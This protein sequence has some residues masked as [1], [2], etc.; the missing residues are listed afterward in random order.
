M[1]KHKS[2][3]FNVIIQKLPYYYGILFSLS[4]FLY[5]YLCVSLT[6]WFWWVEKKPLDFEEVNLNEQQHQQQQKKMPKNTFV[7]YIF[8]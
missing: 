8:V 7:E 1:F 3:T 4:L 6:C 2:T 5:P